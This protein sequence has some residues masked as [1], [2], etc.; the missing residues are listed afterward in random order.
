MFTVEDGTLY[1]TNPSSRVQLK[2][3]LGEGKE[4]FLPQV[5]FVKALEVL[6]E[7][8]KERK[9]AYC[10]THFF[11]DIIDTRGLV[12]ETKGDRDQSIYHSA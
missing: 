3:L 11:V 10:F 12:L 9:D 4:T 8:E 2:L 6:H 1:S 7:S 5:D